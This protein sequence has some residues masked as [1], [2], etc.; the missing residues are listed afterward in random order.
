MKK[1]VLKEQ[2]DEKAVR[3]VIRQEIARIF[4]DLFRKRSM[5]ERP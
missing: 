4:F 5:W 3:T 1:K 2:M